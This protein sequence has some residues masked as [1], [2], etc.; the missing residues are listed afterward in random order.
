VLRVPV[1]DRAAILAALQVQ[2][3]IVLAQPLDAQARP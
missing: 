3:A 1:S 2:P